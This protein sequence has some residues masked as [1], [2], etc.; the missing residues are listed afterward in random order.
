[1]V[2]T[3]LWNVALKCTPTIQQLLVMLQKKC[4]SV[5]YIHDRQALI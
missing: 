5:L 2:K 4:Q 1:M 3:I